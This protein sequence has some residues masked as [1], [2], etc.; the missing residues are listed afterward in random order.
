MDDDLEYGQPTAGED[1][2]LTESAE[3]TES[4]EAG[5]A[6][7]EE[8]TYEIDGREY[9]LSELR[10]FIAGGLRQRDYT[11]KT[12]ELAEERRKI[13]ELRQAAEA[14][15]TIQQYPE[16]LQ[17]L[18]SALAN[19]LYQQSGYS[20]EAGEAGE[21]ESEY[22]SAPWRA[23]I[24]RLMGELA[25]ILAGYE[26]RLAFVDQLQA[27]TIAMERESTARDMIERLRPKFPS[28][29]EDAVI[30]AYLSDTSL[31]PDDLEELIRISHEEEEA[32]FA[33]RERARLEARK[34]NASRRL[35][36]ASVRGF[37]PSAGQ[38]KPP[39]DL[40]EAKMSALRRLAEALRQ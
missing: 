38:E 37:A 23:E 10:E 40:E 13:E 8:P 33:A 39:S 17:A 31:T 12:M 36:G 35:E 16:L 15:Q 1:E 21:Y 3:S 32:K 18:S 34:E 29:D 25:S 19:M 14:W 26:Q 20:E 24:N 2:E 28:V 7:G 4:Y 27:Q 9:T 11:K 30:G 6:E 5:G 22:E